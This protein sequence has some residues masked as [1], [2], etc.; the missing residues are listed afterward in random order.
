MDIL[1]VLDEPEMGQAFELK[2]A[3]TYVGRSE[4]NC[5]RIAKGRYS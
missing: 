2:D 4:V 1:H 5:I 3:P